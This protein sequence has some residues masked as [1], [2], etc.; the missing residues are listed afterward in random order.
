MTGILPAMNDPDTGLH[1][2]MRLLF[3]IIAG[4]IVTDLL[5]SCVQTIPSEPTPR[6]FGEL[7]FLVSTAA[8]FFV[9]RVLVD[10]GLYY[11]RPDTRTLKPV[12]LS[13]MFLLLCDLASY[14]LCYYIVVLVERV[15]GAPSGDARETPPALPHL[16][17]IGYATIGIETLHF[18][19][20]CFALLRVRSPKASPDYEPRTSWLKRWALVSGA[21]AAAGIA[22]LIWGTLGAWQEEGWVAF[23]VLFA[24]ASVITYVLVMR[25]EYLGVWE[26]VPATV[27]GVP[28]T[29]PKDSLEASAP[30]LAT[31]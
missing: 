16:R 3:G 4:L 28:G 1:V 14:A 18:V 21:S 25:P 26:Y 12:Y 24:L 9:T 10:N 31:R 22:L 27:A 23:I 5:K 8:L 2:S 13:R 7:K 20:C 19:W 15:T 6:A 30:P 29:T 17:A 11:Y